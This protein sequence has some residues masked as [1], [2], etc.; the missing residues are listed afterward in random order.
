[1]LIPSKSQID[2]ITT[3]YITNSCP[4]LIGPIANPHAFGYLLLTSRFYV[5]QD[6]AHVRSGCA[7]VNSGLIK[8]IL[9]NKTL[10]PIP[11][12]KTNAEL[13]EELNI[14]KRQVSKMRKRGEL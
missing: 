13:A 1:M 12:T 2:Q 10:Q 5:C 8:A 4:W 7:P 3:T 6:C 14:T 9:Q 11:H